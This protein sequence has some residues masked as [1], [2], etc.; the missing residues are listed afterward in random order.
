MNQKVVEQPPCSVGILVDRG[1]GG[2]SHISA[3]NVSS[4]VAV[5]FFGG[6]DDREALAYGQR[7]AKHPGIT[8]N[9]IRFLPSP[10]MTVES[11]TIDLNKDDNISTAVDE[12]VLSE[13]NMKKTGDES[14][15]YEERAVS[16]GS[17]AIE[18]MREFSRCNLILVGRAPRGQ[19]AESLHVKTMECWELGPVGSLLMAPEFSTLAS[20]LVVQQFRGPSPSSNTSIAIVHLPEEV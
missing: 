8:L 7:M 20:V 12:R 16:K 19:V 15:V 18:V 10:D 11:V 1:I 14:V 3:S 5:F 6:R 17:D 2:G 13:F 4:T 9:V